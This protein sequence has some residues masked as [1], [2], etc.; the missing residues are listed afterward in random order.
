MRILLVAPPVTTSLSA[1]IPDKY[2]SINIG[3]YPFLGLM[4]L[5][6]YL[7]HFSHHRAEILDMIVEKMPHEV[8]CMYI[9]ERK[10]DIVGIY[11]SSTNI[12]SVHR[13]ATLVRS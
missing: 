5:A 13:I 8:I 9:A 3:Y 11:A 12:S 1:T 4:Y 2:T 7:D 10:P 6:S